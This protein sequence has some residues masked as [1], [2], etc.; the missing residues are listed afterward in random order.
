MITADEIS[1]INRRIREL[2]RE[3]PSILY[4]AQPGENAS[5][6]KLD[7]IVS[8]I[9]P[10]SHV[11][12]AAWLLRA[13]ILVQPFP[14]ANHRTGVAAAE[15]LLRRAGLPFKPTT[16]AAGRFQRKVAA[17]RYQLLGGYD[18]APL[19]ILNQWDDAVMTACQGFVSESLS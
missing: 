10:L 13:I 19:S 17:A 1:A 5:L 12:Q 9:P 11:G 2:A 18:D 6:V 16:E 3:D 7:A 14:D 8:R 15:V 4:G